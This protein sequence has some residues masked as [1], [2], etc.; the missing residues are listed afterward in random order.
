MIVTDWYKSH[1]YTWTLIL[2]E[3]FFH[4]IKMAFD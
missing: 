2:G 4:M 3:M 1:T